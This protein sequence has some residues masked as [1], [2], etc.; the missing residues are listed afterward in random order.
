MLLTLRHS[1][2]EIPSAALDNGSPFLEP[3]SKQPNP[4]KQ[5]DGCVNMWNAAR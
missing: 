1:L 2:L 5:Q 4:A 3:N